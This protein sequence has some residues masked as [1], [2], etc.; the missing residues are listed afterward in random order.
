MNKRKQRKAHESESHVKL[1][2]TQHLDER[3]ISERENFKR[4][5][6]KDHDD[7]REGLKKIPDLSHQAVELPPRM[8]TKTARAIIEATRL[9]FS[10]TP[11]EVAEKLAARLTRVLRRHAIDQQQ[12][13]ALTQVGN[14]DAPLS[15]KRIKQFLNLPSKAF[16]ARAI[17]RIP[18]TEEEERELQ[19]VLNS[20]PTPYDPETSGYDWWSPATER[21]NAIERE[22]LGILNAKPDAKTK[23]RAR[24]TLKKTPEDKGGRPE[25]WAVTSLVLRLADIYE[26]YTGRKARVSIGSPDSKNEGKI[27]G[28]FLRFVLATNPTIKPSAVRYALSIRRKSPHPTV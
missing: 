12:S 7:L 1:E 23:Q 17:H 10:C 15:R 26:D 25:N 18:D 14:G 22:E 24:R 3:E 11:E 28:P 21:M 4:E 5:W 8:D 20:G 9:E 6:L 2:C 16:H 27:G 13:E 19:K